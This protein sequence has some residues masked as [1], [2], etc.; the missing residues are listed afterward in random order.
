MITVSDQGVGMAEEELE[1][2]FQ[3]FYQV[4][5]ST[6]RTFGGMGI[7]LALCQKIIDA[8]GGHVWAESEGKGCGS[9]FFI[10]LPL[11]NE[12]GL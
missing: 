5:G 8:H 12:T 6:T 1:T 10:R 11:D 4:D 7:G 2:I 9:T 3:R